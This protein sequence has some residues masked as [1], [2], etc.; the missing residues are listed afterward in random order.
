MTWKNVK[1]MTAILKWYKK[2]DIHW[3]LNYRSGIFLSITMATFVD[4]THSFV[5]QLIPKY[6]STQITNRSISY[7]TMDEEMASK[8]Q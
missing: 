7:Q 5:F 4:A 8:G 2:D 3:K 1:Q 6:G